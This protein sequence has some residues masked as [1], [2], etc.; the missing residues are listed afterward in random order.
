MIKKIVDILRNIV[1]TVWFL[2][3][4][5]VTVCLL[6]YNEFK[7]TTFGTNSFLIIDSD[8][9]EPEFL[10]GDLLI[11]KRNADNKIDVGD[12]VFYY[13]SFMDSSVLIY[14]DTVQNKYPV[15]KSETTF[16]LDGE[17]VSGEYIIGKSDTAKVFHKM[18]TVLGILT[19]KWG[20]MFLIIFPTLFAIMY[21]IAM[22]I[23][24][25]KEKE[26][27]DEDGENDEKPVEKVPVV[28]ETKQEKAE[29]LEKTRVLKLFNNTKPMDFD[30]SELEEEENNNTKAMNFDDS[31]LEEEENNNTEPVNFDDS[32]LEDEDEK[33]DMDN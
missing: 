27:D 28:D 13:N 8:E 33:N 12:K 14:L 7:V 19:S 20:F 18:G 11:V 32:E 10:E 5:F 4:I 9:M 24:M 3:A 22:I 1:I 25:A 15:T 21:E 2:I 16:V 23:E 29:D 17:R 31:E 6:S 26:E 30:D